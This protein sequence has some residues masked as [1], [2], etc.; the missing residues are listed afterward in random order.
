[1][2]FQDFDVD[3]AASCSSVRFSKL[4][5]ELARSVLYRSIKRSLRKIGILAGRHV[6]HQIVTQRV[7][8]VF[9]R[10]HIWIDDVT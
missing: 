8:A 4:P 1:M 9:V 10:E 7:R 5:N 3:V 6:A 2:I